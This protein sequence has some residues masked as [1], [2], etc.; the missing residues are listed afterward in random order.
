[1][2]NALM[3]IEFAH[4]SRNLDMLNFENAANEATNLSLNVKVLEAARGLGTNL[5]QTVDAL[6]ADEVTPHSHPLHP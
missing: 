3:R 1:M 2:V 4:P 5:S 6:L